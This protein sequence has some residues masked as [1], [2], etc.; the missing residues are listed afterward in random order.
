MIRRFHGQKNYPQNCHL[1][2]QCSATSLAVSFTPRGFRGCTPLGGFLGRGGQR[3][4]GGG[5]GGGGMGGLRYPVHEVESQQ[6]ED[7]AVGE[8]EREI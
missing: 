2:C 4:R 3:G 5:G 8:R 7:E 1:K 6:R